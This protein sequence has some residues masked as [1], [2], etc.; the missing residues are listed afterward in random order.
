[1]V[2][3]DG[4]KHVFVFVEEVDRFDGRDVFHDQP[5]FGEFGGDV[6]V[7][8][9]KL[10]LAVQAE[11]SGLAV[12]QQWKIHLLHERK[13]G[14]DALLSA[15][16]SQ[17]VSVAAANAIWGRLKAARLTGPRKV[18]WADKDELRTCGLSRQKVR[19]AKALAEA[20]IDY[21]ALRLVPEED[22]VATL[23]V[24]VCSFE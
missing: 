20:R 8:G 9:D 11:T 14:F 6:V 17:Q 7:D 21:A 4:G 18:L 1:M 13:D 16:V 10:A 5:Q 3:G 12:D 23:T 2:Q 24:S 19:Y 22:I 15:I